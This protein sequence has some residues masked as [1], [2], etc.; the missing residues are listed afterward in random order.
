[1]AAF[2]RRGMPFRDA[3]DSSLST[4]VTLSYL[5]RKE[6]RV[7]TGSR[8]V[9]VQEPVA[10]LLFVLSGGLPRDLV[11][12]IRRAVEAKDMGKTH[13]H[14]L[15]IAL[16]IAE[17]EAKKAAAL[18]RARSA[19]SCPAQAGL[20][21]WAG[22]RQSN[23]ADAQEYFSGLLTHA[24]SL[25]DSACDGSA[26]QAASVHSGAAETVTCSAA[27][28]GAFNFWL[29]SVGQ[30]FATC[31]SLDDFQQGEAADGS[32]SFER[33]AEA[34]QNSALGPDYVLAITRAVR[35][36][37]ALP[38]PAPAAPAFVADAA[39]PATAAGHPPHPP[40]PVA[41]PCHARPEGNGVR[42]EGATTMLTTTGRHTPTSPTPP[43]RLRL[44]PDLSARTLLDGGWW[45][46]SADPAAELPGLIL[47][48]D[49]RHGPITRIMLGRDGWD[50]SRPRRLRVDGPAGSR[51]VR[52]GW[53]ETMPAGLLI[54]IARAGRTDLLTV[55]P[56]T[57]EPAARAAMEQAAEADNR[58]PTPDLLAVTAA[59]AGPAPHRTAS[60]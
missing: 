8:L 33:L 51:V 25:L 22:T 27:E 30:V 29:A 55:P 48:I 54:A 21:T 18:V 45:P 50:A 44:Q 5:S 4:V 11:R 49:E 56:H 35:T 58:T 15:A 47:A 1:M 17:I 20:L 12:L 9:G 28:M 40:R 46:Q 16:I 34:R 26:H 37:W 2:E 3:F 57:G 36:A 31:S 39:A 32:K 13:L 7:L 6:A 42:Q 38:E 10:D 23:T 14:N 59:A 41:R 53:F 60:S 43:S 19:E 24:L 52:L